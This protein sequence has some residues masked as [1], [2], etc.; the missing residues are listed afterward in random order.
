MGPKANRTRKLRTLR[1]SQSFDQKVDS[2]EKKVKRKIKKK[3]KF[4]RIAG[5]VQHKK[6]ETWDAARFSHAGKSV[7]PIDKDF[8]SNVAKSIASK[9]EGISS[10]PKFAIKLDM[11]G[12]GG[13]EEV[14]KDRTRKISK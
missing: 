6:Y 9:H 14:E 2:E 12:P 3:K 11:E 8:D 7:T 4:P 5:R 1:L 10:L 13:Q